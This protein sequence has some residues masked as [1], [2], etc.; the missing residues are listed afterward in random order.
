MSEQ[1]YEIIAQTLKNSL[2][3]NYNA[4]MSVY[5]ALENMSKTLASKFKEVNKFFD[6]AK[7]LKQVLLD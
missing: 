2:E 7:F 5:N 4:P 3:E 6:D 1:E